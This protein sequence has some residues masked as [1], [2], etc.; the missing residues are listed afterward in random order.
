MMATV[1][2]A[3]TGIPPGDLATDPLYAALDPRIRRG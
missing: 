2:L 1:L 3:S